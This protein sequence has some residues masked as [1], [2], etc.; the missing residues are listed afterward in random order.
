MHVKDSL[1]EREPVVEHP[2]LSGP[3]LQGSRVLQQVAADVQWSHLLVEKAKRHEYA[4]KI[5]E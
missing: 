1:F 2:V 4:N 3:H 5:S